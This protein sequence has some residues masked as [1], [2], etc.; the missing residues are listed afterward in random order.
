[1]HCTASGVGLDMDAQHCDDAAEP[2]GVQLGTAVAGPPVGR[3]L[4]T[5][6]DGLLWNDPE[7][8]PAMRSYS[9][10]AKGNF[11]FDRV[12]GGWRDRPV[13]DL[14]LKK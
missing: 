14:R 3:V 7:V 10:N 2:A 8:A 1:M 6:W 4:P 13:L 12:I 11:Q 5:T 9:T